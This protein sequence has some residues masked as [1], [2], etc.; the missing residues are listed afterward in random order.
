PVL[1]VEPELEPVVPALV[2]VPFE[3][4]PVVPLPLV[5]LDVSSPASPSGC[6][7]V[8]GRGAVRLLRVSGGAV[9]VPA[10]PVPPPTVPFVALVPVPALPMTLPVPAPA[11]PK[12]KRSPVSCAHV[13]CCCGVRTEFN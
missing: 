6:N 9:P 7:P 11:F 3:L 2:A 12:L 8:F 4:V 13:C 5:P 10:P 1:L